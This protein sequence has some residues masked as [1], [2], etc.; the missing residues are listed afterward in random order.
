MKRGL[1]ALFALAT[2]LSCGNSSTA[3]SS[4][5]N[6]STTTTKSVEADTVEL[7][8]MHGKKRCATCIAIGTQ[9]EAVVGELANDKVVIKTI[10]FSTAEGEKIA[11]RYEVASSSLILVKGDK[12]ENLTAMAFQYARNNPELFKKSLKESIEKMVN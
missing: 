5:D 3:K 8:Y 11:D 10:D 12:V 6:N 1:I 2:L 4:E 9:A 7:L